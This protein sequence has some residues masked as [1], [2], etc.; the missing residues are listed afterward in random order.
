[1]QKATL[2][3]THQITLPIALLKAHGWKPGTQFIVTGTPDGILLKPFKWFP[4]TTHADVWGCLKYDGPP[5]TIEDMNEAIAKGV[6]EQ[7]W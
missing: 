2:Q 1:M 5:K 6:K 3:P 4:E 7:G